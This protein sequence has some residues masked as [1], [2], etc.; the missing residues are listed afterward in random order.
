M[1]NNDVILDL[2]NH[3]DDP[4][5]WKLIKNDIIPNWVSLIPDKLAIPQDTLSD[6]PW[7]K[8]AYE[9]GVPMI[10]LLGGYLVGKAFLNN[11]VPANFEDS[12]ITVNEV[13]RQK[14]W[15]EYTTCYES[16]TKG[17]IT[18]GVRYANDCRENQVSNQEL[19]DYVEYFK[20]VQDAKIKIGSDYIALVKLA[21]EPVE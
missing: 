1:S 17:L 2:T 13:T 5:I 9:K 11:N 14:T 10:N 16:N 19:K 21:T 3:K 18:I 20:T 8:K 7:L 12:L 4:E 6:E 15:R